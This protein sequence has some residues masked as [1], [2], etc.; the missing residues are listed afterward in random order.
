MIS[1]IMNIILAMF[2]G[3]AM[4]VGGVFFAISFSKLFITEV[5][6]SYYT[7]KK[8]LR[9]SLKE[10]LSLW[11]AEIGKCFDNRISSDEKVFLP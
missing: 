9:R 4:G 10:I 8:I 5:A 6:D 11:R 3:K 1:A 2:F 7:Y